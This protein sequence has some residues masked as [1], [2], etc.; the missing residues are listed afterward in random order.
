MRSLILFTTLTLPV[1]AFASGEGLVSTSSDPTVTSMWE[2]MWPGTW[3][4]ITKLSNAIVGAS[5]LGFAAWVVTGVYRGVFMTGKVAA[6]DATMLLLRLAILMM[7]LFAMLN[8][9][10]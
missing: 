5:F 8:A 7:A 1:L 6:S 10:G 4:D 9:G 3:N 2:A